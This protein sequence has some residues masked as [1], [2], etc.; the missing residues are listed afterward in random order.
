MKIE[1]KRERALFTRGWFLSLAAVVAVLVGAAFMA[2]TDTA[3]PAQAT[4]ATTIY[5]PTHLE[6]I[7]RAPS[8][9]L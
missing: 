2:A 8:V 5:H 1:L 6:V 9:E 3:Q 4:W 7:V